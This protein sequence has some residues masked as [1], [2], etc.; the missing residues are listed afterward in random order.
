MGSFIYAIHPMGSRD[1]V[2]GFYTVAT[3]ERRGPLGQPAGSRRSKLLCRRNIHEGLVQGTAAPALNWEDARGIDAPQHR[4]SASHRDP[5]TCICIGISFSDH[6]TGLGRPREGPVHG[7]ERGGCCR[8]DAGRHRASRGC[9]SAAGD[10]ELPGSV[11]A[12]ALQQGC[13]ANL[14]LREARGICLALLHRGDPGCAW[15]VQVRGR[16]LPVPSRRPGR[17]RHRG[18]GRPAARVERQGGHVWLLL[19]GCH[20]V[21]RSRREAP[22]SGRDCPGPHLI[23][24]L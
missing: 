14:R 23:G 7:Q 13:R 18:M 15:P 20:P 9:V 17:I 19:C 16:V 6:G 22:A 8:H 11:D 24:L 10:R 1:S 4:A 3:S 2:L 21:A 5:C 12:P